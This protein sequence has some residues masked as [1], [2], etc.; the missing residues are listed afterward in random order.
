VS[1]LF[2]KLGIDWKLLIANTITFFIVLWVLRKFAFRPIMDV[3]EKRQKTVND[4]LSA[5]QRSSEE[6]AAIQEDKKEVLK[7]AK[8]EALAIVNEAKKQGEAMKAKL[9]ADAQAEAAATLEKTKKLLERERESMVQAAKTELADLVISASEKVIGAT[10][11][12]KMKNA[13]AKEA[14]KS[15]PPNPTVSKPF[16]RFL[17]Q[18][19][20]RFVELFPDRDFQNRVL[21]AP[22]LPSMPR[23]RFALIED[24]RMPEVTTLL[25]FQS[26]LPQHEQPDN[27][28]FFEETLPYFERPE[29]SQQ[30]P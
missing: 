30:Y 27:P 11:D 8:S 2:S 3:L 24:I 1:E 23:S 15:F 10:M 25:N 29:P 28:Q 16:D 26:S 6:L 20:R 22:N 14:Y 12:T 17:D 4:G 9:A 18:P 5:A 7:A 13:M 21:H 19:R